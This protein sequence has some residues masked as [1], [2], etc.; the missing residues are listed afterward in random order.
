[1]NYFEIIKGRTG[2]WHLPADVW[3]NSDKRKTICG[4]NVRMNSRKLETTKRDLLRNVDCPQCLKRYQ[5]NKTR[6]ARSVK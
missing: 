3:G 6:P 2:Y 1:M 5:R 4:R